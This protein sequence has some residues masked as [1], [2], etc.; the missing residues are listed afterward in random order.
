[1]Q[2][3]AVVGELRQCGLTNVQFCTQLNALGYRT[4]GGRLWQRPQQISRLFRSV[5]GENEK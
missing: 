3:A 4:R 1:L 2:A 5:R